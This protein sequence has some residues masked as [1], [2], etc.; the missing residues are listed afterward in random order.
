MYEIMVSNPHFI[1]EDQQLYL[2]SKTFSGEINLKK[3]V[4]V[5]SKSN[6]SIHFK[7]YNL[8]EQ[9]IGK[10]KTSEFFFHANKILE[11]CIR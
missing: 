5:L 10:E 7:I 8:L 6:K 2:A 9:K 3:V 4:E 1:S 11:K